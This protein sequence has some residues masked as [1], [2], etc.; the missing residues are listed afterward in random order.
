MFHSYLQVILLEYFH[1]ILM[2]VIGYGFGPLFRRK[3][4]VYVNGDFPQK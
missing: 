2:V 4:L 3:L 1:V